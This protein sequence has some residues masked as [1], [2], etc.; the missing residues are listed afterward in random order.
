MQKFSHV[1]NM[2]DDSKQKIELEDQDKKIILSDHL[3][4]D[5]Q[6][7]S[8]I[9]Y[10]ASDSEDERYEEQNKGSS[11]DKFPPISIFNDIGPLSRSLLLTKEEKVIR[12]KLS[13][14]YM[15]GHW[16]KIETKDLNE[17]HLV[18]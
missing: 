10:E 7:Y 8:K 6:Q 15:F 11:E 17:E 16:N 14:S 12:K 1:L 4:E 9:A 2:P 13:K 3:F 5:M 18:G